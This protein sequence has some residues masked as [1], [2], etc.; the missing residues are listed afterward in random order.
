[1]R[2]LLPICHTHT[3]IAAYMPHAYVY[4]CLYTTRS[5]LARAPPFSFKTPSCQTLISAVSSTGAPLFFFWFFFN[6]TPYTVKRIDPKPCVLD[7]NP[8]TLRPNLHPK[9]QIQ[10]VTLHPTPNTLHPTPY[11]LHP[12]PC[13]LHPTPYTLHPTPCTLHRERAVADAVL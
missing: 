12:A 13:T 6:L 7:P 9:R 1:M 3:Y 2:I 8:Y 11:T 10:T 5:T 4:C